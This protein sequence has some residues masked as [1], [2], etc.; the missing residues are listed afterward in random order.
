MKETYWSRRIMYVFAEEQAMRNGYN[1][2]SASMKLSTL[3]WHAW[4]ERVQNPKDGWKLVAEKMVLHG[5]GKDLEA[6]RARLSHSEMAKINP[7]QARK[8]SSKRKKAFRRRLSSVDMALQRTKTMGGELSGLKPGESFYESPAW[9]MVRFEA[10]KASNG[11]CCMCGRNPIDNGVK[12]HVDHIKPRSYFPELSLDINNLQVL[13][14][15]CNI[16]KSNRDD[17]DWRART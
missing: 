4:G 10:L 12:L 13:C 2:P 14:A 7:D 8:R 5:R 6:M 17:T 11:S 16:G 1:P 15:D 3:I 9:R